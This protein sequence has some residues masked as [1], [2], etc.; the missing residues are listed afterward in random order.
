MSP[1]KHATNAVQSQFREGILSVGCNRL[2]FR[3]R[4]GGSD[5]RF[6]KVAVGL[7]G[8]P[9]QSERRLYGPADL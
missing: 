3:G 8:Y 5:T 7:K 6:C 1:G 2:G 4:V 9:E